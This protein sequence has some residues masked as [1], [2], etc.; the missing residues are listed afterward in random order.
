M[1]SMSACRFTQ[2]LT[3]IQIRLWSTKILLEEEAR[4][5]FFAFAGSENTY[6]ISASVWHFVDSFDYVDPNKV[7]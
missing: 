3:S 1:T 7:A 4:S 5:V 2:Y 6:G